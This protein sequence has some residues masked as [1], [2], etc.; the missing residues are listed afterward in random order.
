MNKQ[1]TKRKKNRHEHM[2]KI[3]D[4][5]ATLDDLCNDGVNIELIE[6]TRRIKCEIQVSS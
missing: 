2:N 6:K 4:L 1:K 5:D 3:Y